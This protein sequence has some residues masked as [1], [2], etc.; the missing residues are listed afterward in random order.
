M[1]LQWI[2]SFQVLEVK[3][4]SSTQSIPKNNNN[5]M[6]NFAC[7]WY[8]EFIREQAIVVQQIQN[9]EKIHKIKTSCGQV[10]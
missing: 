1:V 9:E 10:G 7:S 4:D 3:K 5:K 8:E 2:F 6:L